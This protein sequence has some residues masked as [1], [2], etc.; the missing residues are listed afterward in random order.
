MSTKREL[1]KSRFTDDTVLMLAIAQAL[2]DTKSRD[3]ADLKPAFTNALWQWGNQYPQAGYGGAFVKWPMQPYP[4]PY[5]SYGNGSAMRV[6][7]IG[8]MA[9]NLYEARYLARL[10]AEVTHNHPEGIKGAEAVACAIFLARKGASKETIRKYIVDEFDYDLSRTCDQIRPTYFPHASCQ[11]TVPEAITAFLEGNSFEGV[12]R[13]A[14][15]LGGDCDTLAAISGGIAEAFYGVPDSLVAEMV[16]RLDDKQLAV[17]NR[18]NETIGRHS[19]LRDTEK[20]N[21]TSEVSK[22]APK[23]N[24]LGFLDS[25]EQLEI[26]ENLIEKHRIDPDS[27]SV[28]AVLEQIGRCATVRCKVFVPVQLMSAM[29]SEQYDAPQ[30]NTSFGLSAAPLALQPLSLSYSNGVQITPVY[31]SKEQGDKYD[32]MPKVEWNLR[33]LLVAFPATDTRVICINPWKERFILNA[34]RIETVLNSTKIR[35]RMQ[36]SVGDAFTQRAD[37][38]VLPYESEDS[39][40]ILNS[41]YMAYLEKVKSAAGP[42]FKRQYQNLCMNNYGDTVILPGWNL[43]A[44]YIIVTRFPQSVRNEILNQ[45]IRTKCYENILDTAKRYCLRSIVIPPLSVEEYGY[46]TVANIK[47]AL[48]ATN[49]WRQRHKDYKMQVVH[50]ARDMDENNLYTQALNDVELN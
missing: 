21:E 8:W 40:C 2:M 49:Q 33:D 47:I 18:F 22:K 44:R 29:Q 43:P 12:I 13:T 42:G 6:C 7:A 26:L 39:N 36:I 11:E 27:T 41:S 16:K 23:T 1:I 37:A 35:S 9:D 30:K 32:D 28:H 46:P 25:K 45:S 24:A 34:E 50:L 48:E 15:S 5:N 10:S 17:L 14:V 20:K 4:K 3:E 19:L 31:T 38:I